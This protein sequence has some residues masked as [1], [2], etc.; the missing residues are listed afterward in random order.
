MLIVVVVGIVCIGL[1]LWLFGPGHEES[2]HR[3][4]HPKS[5]LEIEM[6]KIY[7]HESRHLS[8]PR[9]RNDQPARVRLGTL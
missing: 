9:G 2:K 4:D 8:R 1:V 5:D 7:R 6:G 3:A